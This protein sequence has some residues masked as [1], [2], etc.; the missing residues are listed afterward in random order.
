[1]FA[2]VLREQALEIWTAGAED[3]LVSAEAVPVARESYIDE[4]LFGVQVVQYFHETVWVVS[5]FQ[6]VILRGHFVRN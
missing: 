5:P 6:Q 3:H 2:R 1:M 4:Q